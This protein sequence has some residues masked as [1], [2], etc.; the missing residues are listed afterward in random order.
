MQEYLISPAGQLATRALYVCNWSIEKL[1]AFV[2]NVG[3]HR[4][5]TIGDLPADYRRELLAKKDAKGRTKDLREK[6]IYLKR[7]KPS[8]AP[9]PPAAVAASAF[10]RAAPV[11]PTRE[12]DARGRGGGGGVG[13]PLARVKKEK[14]GRGGRGR[15]PPRIRP[16]R[17]K[18]EK[19]GEFWVYVPVK[20]EG[21]KRGSGQ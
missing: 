20:P 2:V 15:A 6:V 9:S 11:T 5:K 3:P 19:K 8:P 10:A 17:V 13:T 18:K 16:I 1:E 4:K 7:L 12:G 14:E 21:K